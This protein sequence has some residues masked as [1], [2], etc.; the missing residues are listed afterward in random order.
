M[1]LALSNPSGGATLGTSSATLEI[2]DND[3]TTGCI[4]D[5]TTLC[6]TNS[7]RFRIQINWRTVQDDTG[8]GRVIPFAP[9]D[10]GLFWFFNSDNAEVLVKV[11][12]GCG[13]NNHF[14]VF[15]A[16]STDV[17]YTMTVTDT[18]SGQSKSYFN[19]L[20]EQAPAITDTEAFATCP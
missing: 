18:E 15:A 13:I 4:A 14:W 16:A 19:D 7:E 2:I 8:P 12:N 10:S 5:D 17:E 20:G 1:N 6:L 11:L 9:V 3:A